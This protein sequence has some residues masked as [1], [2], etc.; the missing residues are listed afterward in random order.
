MFVIRPECDCQ[1]LRGPNRDD[2][3][4]DVSQEY[5]Q[6]GGGRGQPPPGQ[7]LNEQPRPTRDS[8]PQEHGAG[9]EGVPRVQPG[10]EGRESHREHC[11]GHQTQSRRL[12]QPGH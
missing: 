6:A 11:Q 4:P 5:R 7:R 1:Q 2:D 9:V 8:C 12:I 10:P 3:G